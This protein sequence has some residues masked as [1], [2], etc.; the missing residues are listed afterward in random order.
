MFLSTHTRARVLIRTHAH[1]Q[2]DVFGI[3]MEAWA[4]GSGV[5]VTQVNYVVTRVGNMPG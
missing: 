1:C 5:L 4:E 3:D 2:S